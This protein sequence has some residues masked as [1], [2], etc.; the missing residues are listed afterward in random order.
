MAVFFWRMLR[1]KYKLLLIYIVAM[2]GLLEMYVALFPAIKKQSASFD[3]MIQSMPEAMFKAFG[4]DPTSFSFGS[5]QS[6]LSSEYMS[7]L[8]PLLAVT[9]TVS[10]ANYIAVREADG[11]TIETLLSLPVRRTRV[12]LERY[13]A[14]LLM[15]VTF[16]AVSMLGALPLAFMHG[17]DFEAKNFVV[18]TVGSALFVVTVYTMATA[19]SVFFT[20]RSK[21]TMTV[22]GVLVLMYVLNVVSGLNENLERLR[23][24]SIFNYFN[25]AELLGRAV[26]PVHM[27][28]VLGGATLIL[29]AFSL[30]WFNRRD[31]SA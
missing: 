12:F 26:Y 18:A 25:G 17:V 19:C 4:M 10:V 11:G 28:T 31:Y 13:A 8:W 16:A 20:A 9:F 15:V 24:V 22:S 23:Y 30:W 7:F 27:F 5:F 6:Y 29:I 3:Q 14:G 2:L 21:A 1:D